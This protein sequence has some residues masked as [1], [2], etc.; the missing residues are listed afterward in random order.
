MDKIK[1]I[2]FSEE[3]ID[4]VL[5]VDNLS[6]NIPWS[7]Q[8]FLEEVH[9]DF[10][11]YVV[12]MNDKTIVGYAGVWIIAGEGQI[13]NIAVQPALRGMGIASRMLEAII[14]ICRR[15]NATG[16]TLEVR[17]SNISAIRLYKKY[18]FIEEGMRKNF[19]ADNNEDAII[20]WK[21]DIYV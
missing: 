9:N 10:A 11:E 15:A 18:G 3:H 16:I 13:T 12:A 17:K 19:Y 2:P 14:D 8:S 4:G 1:I 6:F 5:V 7:K 21:H 20:M